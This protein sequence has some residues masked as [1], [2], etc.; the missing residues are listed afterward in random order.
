MLRNEYVLLCTARDGST[1]V[2]LYDVDVI[3]PPGQREWLVRAWPQDAVAPVRG[4]ESYEV[5]LE[6]IDPESV[7]IVAAVNYLQAPYVGRGVAPSLY[8]VLARRLQRRLL[9]SRLQVPGTNEWR[10]ER[11]TQIWRR[12][13]ELGEADEYPSDGSFVIDGRPGKARPTQAGLL[14]ERPA[15]ASEAEFV[16]LMEAVDS[17]LQAENVPIPAREL[18]GIRQLCQ[19]L[20][21]EL[22]I[23]YPDREPRDGVYE[24]DDLAMRATRWFRARYGDRL[25]VDYSPG[26]MVVLLRGDVWVFILPRILGGGRVVFFASRTEPTTLPAKAELIR[27]EDT[28]QRPPSRYNILDALV[29]LSDELRQALTDDELRALHFA[30]M[31]GLGAYEA[32]RKVRDMRFVPEA[33]ADHAQTVASLT[34]N[35]HAHPGQ[36]RWSAL[37]ATEKMYKAYLKATGAEV[38]PVHN[39]SRLSAVAAE[40]GLVEADPYL[41]AAVQ[42]T[43][44]VRYGD[45]PV[46]IPEAIAAHHAALDL[47]WYIAEALRD[48]CAAIGNNQ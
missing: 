20:A 13:V 47:S 4:G 45:V 35:A 8:P 17:R 2:W 29:G 43:A 5:R 38:P 10:A 26:R 25:N 36:A 18:A 22:R 3:G 15:P 32:M 39:L 11:A 30:F 6:E 40:R 48:R 28:R 24:G 33:L 37:Q 1:S 31:T 27:P 41:V 14:P 21:L 23:T 44:G 9:S 12:L 46:S 16:A 7:R 42:C 34:A 19:I